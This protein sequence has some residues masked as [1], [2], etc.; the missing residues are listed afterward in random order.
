MENNTIQIQ[1]VYKN[2]L[3]IYQ[4]LFNSPSIFS[5]FVDSGFMLKMLNW[6]NIVQS[7]IPKNSGWYIKPTCTFCISK[8]IKI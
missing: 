2:I 7:L 6:Y 3:I 1:L 8:I 5:L 4:L